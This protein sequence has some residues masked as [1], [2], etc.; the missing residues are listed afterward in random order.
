MANS[1]SAE[2]KQMVDQKFIT[3]N[4]LNAYNESLTN[5][6]T[7]SIMNS[8]AEAG[9]SLNQSAEIDIGKIT[10]VGPGSIVTG[11]DV[12]IDQDSKLDQKAILDSISKNDINTELT[13]TIMN[14]ITNKLDLEQMAKLVSEAESKQSVAGFALTGGNTVN[15]SSTN[16]MNLTVEQITTRSL[17]NIV[18]TVINQQT[19]SIDTKKCIATNI[20]DSLI[21]IG[22][23]S[24]YDGGKVEG[25]S[26]TIKQTSA[27]VNDCIL[28]TVQNSQ[29]T[30][31]IA[32]NLGLKIVD[33]T[34]VKQTAEGEAKAK[35]DQTITGLLDFTGS[36]I[37]A[38]LCILSIVLLCVLKMTGKK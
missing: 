12:K 2:V 38:V 31:V 17:T 10:A 14:D 13:K 36:L 15:T 1:S 21:R 28:K 37:V 6:T 24:A 20:Q 7:Q 23:I 34:K 30:S 18:N 27:V 3:K 33:E 11:I 29:I 25:I 8:M 4:S 9:S 22:E 16:D 32:E 19:Q 5:L 35:S 26:L